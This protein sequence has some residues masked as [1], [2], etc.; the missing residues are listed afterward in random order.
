MKRNLEKFWPGI[1]LGI[2]LKRW[3]KLLAD[4][5]YSVLPEFWPRAI[6]IT[7]ISIFNSST[8]LIEKKLYENDILRTEVLPPTFILGFYRSGTSFLHNLMSIDSRFAFPTVY[9]VRFPSSF[10]S[11]EKF[12]KKF[13]LHSRQ[14][15]RIQDNVKFTWSS[16]DEDEIALCL[17]T[18][19]SPLLGRAFPKRLMEY[20][21]FRNFEDVSTDEL[22]VWCKAVEWYAKKLTLAYG[23]PMIMKSPP[24]TGRIYILST[25]F[26][27]AKFIHIH[28]NPYAV[29]Q[30]ALHLRSV[31]RNLRQFQQETSDD[32]EVLLS[33][34]KSTYTRFF[35]EKDKIP[36]HNL[37]DISYEHL[38]QNPLDV[39]HNIY[40]HLRLP[41][42]QVVENSLIEYVGGIKNYRKNSH[43]NLPESLKNK[44]KE[45]CME[46]FNA[47][48]YEP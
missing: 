32:D 21:R 11:T 48:G 30:S 43:P 4:N 37:I 2:T 38:E 41:D 33:Q 27:G 28:R 36:I 1:F 5:N 13:P 35:Q 42:F 25:I 18:L 26:P 31:T 29:F 17:L 12:A 39:I 22:T 6:L 10:L 47:W 8:A 24:H 23:R 3:L 44:I 9:Q 7:L 40:D 19:A 34:Y 20:E 16:P 14:V 45:Q 46:C 15:K